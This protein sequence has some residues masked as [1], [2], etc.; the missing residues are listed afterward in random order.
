LNAGPKWIDWLAKFKSALTPLSAMLVIDSSS[1]DETVR[2]A[3]ESGFQIKVIPRREFSH[4][5]T[6]QLAVEHLSGFDLIVFMT[7]DAIVASPDAIENLLEPFED[8]SVGLAFGRQLPHVDAGAI[9]AHA[10]LFNYPDRSATRALGMER[11]LGLKSAFVSNS[12]AAYRR[13]ALIDVGGFPS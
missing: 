7:Q 2:L 13:R 4:G 6:R 9:G 1:D 5:G 12:F 10:R 11:E 8:A 3:R